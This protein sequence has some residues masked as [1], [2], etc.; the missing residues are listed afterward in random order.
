VFSEILGLW[1]CKKFNPGVRTFCVELYFLLYVP[2][3]EGP[4]GG[5][6]HNDPRIKFNYVLQEIFNVLKIYFYI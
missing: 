4:G 5:L 1:L 3:G 6:S 2:G